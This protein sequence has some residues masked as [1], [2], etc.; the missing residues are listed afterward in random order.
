L[1]VIIVVVQVGGASENIYMY[2]RR[3]A[4]KM[5]NRMKLRPTAE[6]GPGNNFLGT[7]LDSRKNEK[8]DETQAH[9][10]KRFRVQLVMI[11]SN[12]TRFRF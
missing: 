11:G 6:K 1:R 5:K 12:N 2:W 3:S 4:G 9:C 8:Q 10:R 7:N